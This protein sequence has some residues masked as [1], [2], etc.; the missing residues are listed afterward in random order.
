MKVEVSDE[1]YEVV[2]AL[3]SFRNSV[4]EEKVKPMV[5]LSDD[6]KVILK[7]II[8]DNYKYIHRDKVGVLWI[9]QDRWLV[10]RPFRISDSIYWFGMYRHLFQFIQEGEEYSIKRLLE[11]KEEA[12]MPL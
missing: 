2:K 12:E 9:T 8:T 4:D 10:A 6:E 11:I 5:L 7:N 3:R 1:E